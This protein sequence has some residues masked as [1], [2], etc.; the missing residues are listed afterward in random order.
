MLPKAKTHISIPGIEPSYRGKVR[1]IYDLGDS[2]VL[3]ATDRI[4]A[5]DVVF[6]EGI[7]EK[8]EI[9]TRISNH[10]FSILPEKNALIE[11]NYK[12]LPSPFSQIE[13]LKDRI[14]WVKK[15]ERIPFE[16]IVRGFL[17]GSIYEAYQKSP[18]DVWGISLPKDL[19]KGSPLEEYLFTPSTKGEKGEKDVMVPFSYMEEK[20]GK[21]VASYLKE[22]SLRLYRWAREKLEEVGILLVDTKLEFGWYDG[23][24]LLIDEVFTPDS[25]RFWK[26][27]DY[28][29]LFPQGKLPESLDKEFIR[30][31][32]RK[33]GWD[34]KPPPPS[35]PEEI[36]VK[37]H[38]RYKWIEK[39][40]QSLS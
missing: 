5:F 6:N 30:E 2:L 20:L 15:V 24:I 28:E 26:K 27:E 40:I 12:K 9:L 21:E 31:Y 39:R 3:V 14:Q 7:P 25:S 37:T 32:L 16:C 29:K 22:T 19:K 23:E 34:R 4:S 35:L 38:E 18:E 13:E 8:G 17:V 36:I 1:D 11:T 33:I 10:W